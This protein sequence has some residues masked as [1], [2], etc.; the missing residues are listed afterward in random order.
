MA[1]ETISTARVVTK[2][3][4]RYGKQLVSHLSRRSVGHWDPDTSTGTLNMSGGA[5][6]VTLTSTV[7]ALLLE[8]RAA[9][10]DIAN[11]E[12]VLGRHLVRFA[13]RDELHVQW[14]RS[15]GTTGTAQ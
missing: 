15:D 13:D 10:T 2:R 9:D 3:A 14:E 5:A 1:T 12:D 11:Y 4:P 6:H 8:I 7:E